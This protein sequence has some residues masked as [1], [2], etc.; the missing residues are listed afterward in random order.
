[1]KKLITLAF[2]SLFAC[3]A[4]ASGAKKLDKVSVGADPQTLE[5]GAE[6]VVTVCAGCHSLKYVK[7]RDLLAMGI[8]KEKVD[9]WRGG[10]AP[11]AAITSSM[12]PEVAIKGFGIVPPDL[13]LMANARA[14]RADYVYSFLLGYFV[15]PQGGGGNRYLEGTKMPDVLGIA[16]AKTDAERALVAE[17]AR[18]VVSFMKWVADPHAQERN[19]LGK[20]VIAYLVFL[21]ILLL[22]V[23][24]RVWSRVPSH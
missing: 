12:P 22:L 3:N 2:C 11:S 20:Y 16:G 15:S 5:R 4:W 18:D 1:M 8:P 13:S 21:S 7:Y 23:K 24:R 14:G 6:I 19:S 10:N 9:S 17:K